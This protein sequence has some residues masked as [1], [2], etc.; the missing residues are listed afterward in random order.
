MLHGLCM[1]R[2]EEQIDIEWSLFPGTIKIF[3]ARI[4][5][6]GSR[7]PGNSLLD[8]NDLP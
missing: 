6:F 1:L 8:I 3:L 5:N 2:S 7:S 4:S